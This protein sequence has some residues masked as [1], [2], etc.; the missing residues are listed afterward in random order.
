MPFSYTSYP[1][2][3]FVVIRAKGNVTEEGMISIARSIAQD[4]QC[5]SIGRFLYDGS[6]VTGHDLFSL[7][8]SKAAGFLKAAPQAR[9][10]FLLARST[11]LLVFDA[12]EAYC[13][14]VNVIPPKV[15]FEREQALDYLNEGVPP[16]KVIG[17][18][19]SGAGP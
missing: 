18:A 4:P 10:A 3:D 5:R 7:S 14:S 11:D 12:Y 19:E 15:F 16:G 8:V 13:R 9:R 2:K 17:M 1:E 6:D